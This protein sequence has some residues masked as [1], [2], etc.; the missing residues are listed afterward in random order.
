MR[1][2]LL[3]LSLYLKQH[4]SEYYRLLDAVRFNGDWEAWLSF[5]LDGVQ[6]TANSA[7]DTAHRLLELFQADTQRIHEMGRQSANALLVLGL[8]RQRP[9]ATLK[10]LTAHGKISFTTASRAVDA[11]IEFG[12]LSE[13]TGRERNRVF[14]YEAYLSILNEGAEHL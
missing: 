12:I 8:L 6:Q 3:Y 14:A 13:I 2:P 4:R 1:Q 5:F 7:V 9:V 11:L 10:F